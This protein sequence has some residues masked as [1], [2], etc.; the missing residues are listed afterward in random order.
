M[1][2]RLVKGQDLLKLGKMPSSCDLALSDD[3]TIET[4]NAQDL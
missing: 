2:K 1:L 4:G 3:Q